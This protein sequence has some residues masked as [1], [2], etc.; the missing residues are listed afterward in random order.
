VNLLSNALDALRGVK[1]PRRLIVDSYVSAQGSRVCVTVTDNGP[2]VAPEIAPRLF[3][4]FASTK[5]RRGTGL[6]LYISRQL[7]RETEG[8]LEL[9]PH[10]DGGARFL[11]WL[12]AT[13]GSVTPE[14]A[15]PAPAKLA[16][17]ASLVGVRVL[18]VDDE[19][20]IRRPMSRFLTKRGAEVSE[21]GDGIAA[22][23]TIRAGLDPRVILADLRMPRMDGAEFY[24][25]LLEERPALAGRVMFLSGDITHLAGRGLAEI[26]RDRVLVKPVELA[27]LERRI[28]EFVHEL[29]VEQC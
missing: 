27:E 4:P 2:G 23:E 7:L 8:D 15:P 16:T 10:S 24:E 19:E 17:A 12:P 18:I 25:Q 11:V 29:T 20:L 14:Q 26:P 9:A 1:P 21:A 28:R 3:R 5:G 22:L 13:P 6:G